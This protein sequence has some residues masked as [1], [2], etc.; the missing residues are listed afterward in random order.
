LEEQADKDA[1][2]L[3]TLYRNISSYDKTIADSIADIAQLEL[4]IE[5]CERDRVSYDL[6]REP[7]LEALAEY[8]ANGEVVAASGGIVISVPVETGQ[9]INEN[10]LMATVGVGNVFNVACTISLDNNFVF[11]G[12]ECVLSNTAHVLYGMIISIS[13]GERGKDLKVR[14]TSDDIT[15][16]ETFE[17]KFETRSEVRYTL[18][19]N[20]ALNQDS[21]GYYL[22]QIKQ[23]DGL[24]GK[25]YY[26]ERLDVYIGDSD[27]QNTVLTGGVRFFEPIVL[28][29]DK[30]VQPGDIVSLMNEGD[31]FAD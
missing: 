23:R 26:L 5:S 12:D 24:L 17:I 10:A 31:F 16:G 18:A 21:D 20:G 8:D 6:Q 27:S 22:N 4:D 11:P 29:S 9:T 3:D 28:T 13:P 25:E 7:Y 14:V 19:P 1:D 2:T 30:S 15:A